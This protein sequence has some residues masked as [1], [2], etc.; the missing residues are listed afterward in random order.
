[1]EGVGRALGIEFCEGLFVKFFFLNMFEGEG[2]EFEI[3]FIVEFILEFNFGGKNE[4][5]YYFIEN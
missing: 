4:E 5:S 2:E 3:G 1:M